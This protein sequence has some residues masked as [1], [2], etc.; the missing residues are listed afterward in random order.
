[1]LCGGIME[2]VFSFPIRD[3]VVEDQPTVD[4]FLHSLGLE[5]YAIH[6]KAEEVDLYSLKQMGDNDLKELGVPMGP[7]KKILLA[8]ASRA[9]RQV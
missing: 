9:R 5:K 8:L 6:F 2:L 4:S 7:R 1:M 3:K